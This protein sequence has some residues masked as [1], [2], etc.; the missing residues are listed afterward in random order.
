M[1]KVFPRSSWL[2]GNLEG[3]LSSQVRALLK[4]LGFTKTGR[5][6]TRKRGP[7]WDM[8]NFQSN[9]SNRVT[10][11]QS[12]FVNVGVGSSD[13]DAEVRTFVA[14]PAHARSIYDKRWESVVPDLPWEV[15]FDLGTQTDALGALLCAGLER[16]LPVLEG[17]TT[18]DE[19]VQWA[20]R[21]NKLHRMELV[22]SYLAATGDIEQLRSYI[23]ALR[24]DFGHQP[25]WEVF[26]RE[27]ADATYACSDELIELGILDPLPEFDDYGM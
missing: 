20:V 24:A 27:L 3:V 18:T 13:V 4:P 5:T 22:C 26:N 11:Y 16:V 23:G 15:I 9:R 17:F 2:T 10:P 19:L 21:N 8:I 12:F 14:K 25:R 6:F 1:G 7:L